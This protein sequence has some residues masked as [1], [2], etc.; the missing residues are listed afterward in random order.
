MVKFPVFIYL[1]L[2][3][4]VSLIFFELEVELLEEVVGSGLKHS[5]IEFCFLGFVYFLV[6]LEVLLSSRLGAGKAAEFLKIEL[7]HLVFHVL[8]VSKK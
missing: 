7:L 4:F 3:I 5:H 1:F 2:I 8:L 6:F